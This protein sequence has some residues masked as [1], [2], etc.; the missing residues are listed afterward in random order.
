MADMTTELT[1]MDKIMAVTI[2]KELSEVFVPGDV[3]ETDDGKPL[4]KEDVEILL[5]VG[6][7]EWAK[8]VGQRAFYTGESRYRTQLVLTEAGSDMLAEAGS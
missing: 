3:V 1:Q 8:V 6:A 7:A 4:P 5:S 2:L